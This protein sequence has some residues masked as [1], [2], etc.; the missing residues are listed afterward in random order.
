MEER[1]TVKKVGIKYGIYLTLISIIYTL[2]L[3]IFDLAAN[4]SLGYAG[5]VFLIIALVLAHKE[6]KEDNDYM[7]YSQGLGISMIII[8]IN[9]VVSSI[10]SYI[11]IKFIDDSMLESIR[12]Q[13]MIEMEQRGMSD[14]QI[15]RAMEM[16]ATFTSP[17]M[18]LVFG[19]I[20]SIFIG[21]I[22]ALIITAITKKSRPEPV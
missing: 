11:Y 19:I 7:S 13:A 20:G 5:F 14:S 22:I 8:S 9:A 17:E 6:Y 12:E 15:E 18:I 3:H 4:Q 21:F 10:F 1:T 2:I 16:Q